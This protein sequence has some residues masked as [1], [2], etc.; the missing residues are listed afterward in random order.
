MPKTKGGLQKVSNTKSGLANKD[1]KPRVRLTY[2]GR[3]V[4]EYYLAAKLRYRSAKWITFV[5]LIAFLLFNLIFFREN[6]TY[7]NM[8][9]L[10]RDLDTGSYTVS[11]EFA[12]ATYSEESNMMFDIYKGKMAL[13]AS[14]G[15]S[16]FN[17]A[18]SREFE[19][20]TYMQNPRLECGEKYA[21]AYD[22]GS[23][24]YGIFNSMGKVMS[25]T[26]DFTIEDCAV[27][28]TGRFALLTRSGESKYLVTVYNDKLKAEVKYYRDSYVVD[29]A[30]DSS[31][32]TLVM[33][34]AKITGSGIACEIMLAEKGKEETETLTI[35]NS[36]PLAIEYMKDG[37]IL[38]FCEDRVVS[39]E[40]K[41]VA[42]EYVFSS[43][44]PAMFDYSDEGLAVLCSTNAVGTDNEFYV[45]DSKAKNVYSGE[46]SEKVNK[47][48]L[49][50]DNTVYLL[51]DAKIEKRTEDAKKYTCKT[52]EKVIDILAYYGSL[53]RCEA[54]GAFVCEFKD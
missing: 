48:A 23:N 16:I 28:D 35:A 1:S 4:N 51:C 53:I 45:F 40:G 30:M 3:E 13:A 14:S 5:L 31:G 32:K 37:G 47:I 9:Y 36:M 34:A 54:K 21:I 2:E 12:G 22:M 18:G 50:N 38:V 19:D 33:A 6:I 26:S 46:I 49:D 52:D 20:N 8:M 15:F 7:A 24:V 43:G 11:G 17:T 42:N 29:M 39:L 44:K 27:S 10:L 25:G 41:K